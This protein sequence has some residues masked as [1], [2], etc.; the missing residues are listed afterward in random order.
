MRIRGLT[1]LGRKLAMH[2]CFV[3]MRIRGLTSLGRELAMHGYFV[4]ARIR[5]VTPHG[6]IVSGTTG[7]A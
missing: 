1:S 6:C 5:P 2:G 4:T 7:G 3:T